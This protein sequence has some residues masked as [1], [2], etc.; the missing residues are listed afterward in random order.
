MESFL[1]VC[2]EGNEKK[3]EEF[4]IQKGCNNWERGLQGACKGG[5]LDII[6]LMIFKG[7]KDFVT[8]F[9]FACSG[10]NLKIV[11]FIY[12]FIDDHSFIFDKALKTI[13]ISLDNQVSSN[14]ENKLEIFNNYKEIYKFVLKEKIIFVSDITSDYILENIIS[15]IINTEPEP[16]P[17]SEKENEDFNNNDNNDN[18][19]NNNDFNNEN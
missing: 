13:E 19:F 2:Y 16:E 9:N 7:A 11:K 6:K 14:N 1:E 17:E 5:H 12:Q 10:G 8:A 18:D 4:I 15:Y 3:I